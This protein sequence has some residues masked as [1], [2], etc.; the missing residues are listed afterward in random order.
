[1]FRR[2]KHPLGRK[3]ESKP[4]SKTEPA[5]VIKKTLEE[6]GVKLVRVGTK[7]GQ[8]GAF[9]RVV[10][11]GQRVPRDAKGLKVDS[12]EYQANEELRRRTVEALVKIRPGKDPISVDDAKASIQ[13]EVQEGA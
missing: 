1:M 6:A 4:L 13:V 10:V 9:L 3:A 7:K 11:E 8:S 5:S 2:L 12:P